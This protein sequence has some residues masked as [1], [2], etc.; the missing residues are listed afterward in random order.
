MVLE[1]MPVSEY[2][3]GKFN[4]SEKLLWE[5]MMWLCLEDSKRWMSL[6]EGWNSLRNLANSQWCSGRKTFN[7]GDV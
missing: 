5:I 3:N 7:K 4:C 1:C 6:A 2:G